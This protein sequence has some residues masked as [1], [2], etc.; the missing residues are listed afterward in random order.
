DTAFSFIHDLGFIPKIV[1]GKRGFKVMIGGG[2]GA[3]PTLSLKAYDFLPEDQ[4]IPL[5]E[6]VLR[7][8]DRYGERNRRMKAR[9]KFLITDIGLEKTMELVREEWKAIRHKVYPI[10]LDILPPPVIP[11]KVPV[12]DV[13]IK[14][15]V[16]FERWR[17][18]NVIAQKQEGFFG[19][20]VKLLLGNL[21]S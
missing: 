19:V 8:F 10:N 2:L 9:F 11:D 21:S 18:T 1:D 13:E 5:T 7:V 16:K 15:L 6:A 17:R 3:N 20:Y 4:V 14:D 12:A